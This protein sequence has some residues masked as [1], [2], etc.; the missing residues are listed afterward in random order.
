[1]GEAT[2]VPLARYREALEKIDALQAYISRL[3]LRSEVE[4][5]E[6]EVGGR[7]CGTRDDDEKRDFLFA[8]DDSFVLGDD[9]GFSFES[10]KFTP[11]LYYLL[12]KV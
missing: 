8:Y 9:G 6:A 2:N 7:A 10:L 1:M 3:P 11:L 5:L 12:L 4:K